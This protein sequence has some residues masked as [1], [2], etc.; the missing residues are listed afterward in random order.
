MGKTIDFSTTKINTK[1]P[2]CF[3]F[4]CVD[5]KNACFPKI[6]QHLIQYTNGKFEVIKY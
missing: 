5:V 3:F 6:L 1:K 4:K 2:N